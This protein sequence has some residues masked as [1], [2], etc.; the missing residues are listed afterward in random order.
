MSKQMYEIDG[1]D[2]VRK[3]GNSQP[4]P[5]GSQPSGELRPEARIPTHGE[6]Q[7]VYP[8]PNA[9]PETKPADARAGWPFF[10]ARK[11]APAA[12]SEKPAARSAKEVS[13]IWQ[14]LSTVI[15]A[16][17]IIA[18]LFSL[19]TPG[20]TISQNLADTLIGDASLQSQ[21]VA[22]ATP[23]ASRPENFPT[24]RIGIVVGHRGNDTGAVCTNGLTELEVNTNIATFLQQKLISDGYEVELLDEFDARL[25]NYEAGLLLSIHADSCDYINDSATGFKLAAALSEVKQETSDRLVQCLADRYANVT[26]LKYHYQTVTTDMTYYHAFSEISPYTTAAIIEVGFLNLDQEILTQKPELLAQGI[27][28]GIQ[29]YLKNEGVETSSQPSPTPVP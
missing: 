5:Q 26:G 3:P 11:P 6:S 1:E 10:R 15:S 18:T 27:E 19:W 2:Q 21:N 9:A 16:A 13:V 7:S 20:S 28:A 22:F 24:N 25:Q 23:L 8:S 14:V 17:F 12:G 4:S 29:C